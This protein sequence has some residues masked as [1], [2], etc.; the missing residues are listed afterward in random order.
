MK[1]KAELITEILD[2]HQRLSPGIRDNT[3]ETW[4]SLNLTIAQ[5]KS[6]VFIN[7]ARVTNFKSLAAA[8]GVSPPNVTG[9]VDRMV[10]HGLI[11]REENPDNRRMVLLK[12]TPKGDSV[13]QDIYE[14]GA[15]RFGT[16]LNQLARED[17]EA[18][19]QGMA[20]LDAA[21]QKNSS[22][23]MFKSCHSKKV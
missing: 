10:E 15:A 4:L 20:A 18:L 11:S 6:L 17:L 16:L 19:A 12:T 22:E 5:L 3:P 13:I 2:L 23:N 21:L 1:N 8:L 14:T 7:H 9:I